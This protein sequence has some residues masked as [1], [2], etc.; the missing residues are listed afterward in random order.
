MLKSLNQSPEEVSADALN[1]HDDYSTFHRLKGFNL[2]YNPFGQSWF[3][4]ICLINKN[5]NKS[6]FVA[7]KTKEVIAALYNIKYQN[8]QERVVVCDR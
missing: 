1:V 7:E 5:Y 6:P 8:A 2:K 4:E 3:L